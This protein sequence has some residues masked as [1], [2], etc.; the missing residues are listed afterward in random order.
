MRNSKKHDSF[1]KS[2]YLDEVPSKRLDENVFDDMRGKEVDID[3]GGGGSIGR[4]QVLSVNRDEFTAAKLSKDAKEAQSR[5]DFNK[6]MYQTYSDMSSEQQRDPQG[7]T[8]KTGQGIIQRRRGALSGNTGTSYHRRPQTFRQVPDEEGNMIDVQYRP[9]RDIQGRLGFFEKEIDREQAIIDRERGVQGGTHKMDVVARDDDGEYYRGTMTVNPDGTTGPIQNA[10]RISA[11][12]GERAALRGN[13]E[14]DI[15]RARD[16]AQQRRSSSNNI[17]FALE[18]ER[19][20][21][22]DAMSRIEGERGNI[23]QQANVIRQEAQN[24]RMKA[25]NEFLSKRERARLRQLRR[26]LATSNKLEYVISSFMNNMFKLMTEV[27]AVPFQILSGFGLLAVRIVRQGVATLLNAATV[28]ART[29]IDASRVVISFLGKAS[30][31]LIRG[32]AMLLDW[33]VRGGTGAMEIG[34]QIFRLIMLMII[35]IARQMKKM[36]DNFAEGEGGITTIMPPKAE[37]FTEHE[38]L[39]EIVEEFDMYMKTKAY[40]TEN[41]EEVMEALEHDPIEA[42]EPLQERFQGDMKM[43]WEQA[44]SKY[45]NGDYDFADHLEEEI[46]A[47]SVAGG[48]VDFAPDAGHP[49]T[50]LALSNGPFTRKH[51]NV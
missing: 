40:M 8:G 39:E 36:V 12:E 10:Q 44:S 13:S 7:Y 48:G 18:E 49:K 22:D 31:A 26:R 25:E 28:V 37:G 30:Q 34:L 2:F 24:L 15:A 45:E 33:T 3:G 4:G 41:F 5:L 51:R 1:F 38:G 42:V 47:N 17:E 9:V 11:T 50:R 32:L 23:Q 16:I 20:R 46:A 27:L 21:L 43:R 19:N 29:A 6:R 14:E 35:K